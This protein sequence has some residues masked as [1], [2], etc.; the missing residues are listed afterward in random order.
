[1]EIVITLLGQETYFELPYQLTGWLGWLFLVFGL[2][3]S[4]TRVL[5]KRT[6]K[7]NFNKLAFGVLLISVPVCALFLGIRLPDDQTLPIPITPVE[8]FSP[9]L[10]F[11]AAIPWVFAAGLLSPVS[12][13]AIGL[14]SGVVA[15]LWETHSVFTPIEIAGIA[16]V[17]GL[18]IRQRYRT[19]F[20]KFLRHPIFSAIF[21][22][23][24]SIPFLLM[25]SFL[26]GKG[27][28][29]LRVDFA[30]TRIWP[31]LISQGGQ[32][33]I[34]SL[35]A[36]IV[37]L[38]GWKA[39]GSKGA[40]VPSPE[41]TSLLSRF[42]SRSIPV[43]ITLIVALL[44]GDWVVAGLSAR[45]LINDQLSNSAKIAA[46]GLPYFLESGQ[47]L[48]SSLAQPDLLQKSPSELE[49][50]FHN[51]IQNTFFFKQLYLFNEDGNPVS[52]YPVSDFGQLKI[53]IEENAGLRL[54]LK[55]VPVQIYTVPPEPGKNSAQISFIASILGENGSPAGVILGRTDLQSNPFTLSSLQ[56]LSEINKSGGE[57]LILDEHFRILFHPLPNLVMTNYLGK[58]PSSAQ[59]F[60]DTSPT[61]T[62]QLV[63]A[64]PLVGQ[65]WTV[66]VKVPAEQ[67][68]RLALNLSL[69][70]LGI[71]FLLLAVLLVTL[72]LG[73]N[74]VANSL[75]SLANETTLI[76][77]GQLD[78]PLKLEGEDE[79]GRLQKA[80]ERMRVSLRAR[81]FELNRLLNVSQGAASSLRIEDAILP[82]LEAAAVYGATSSRV[83]LARDV[84]DDSDKQNLYTQGIGPSTKDFS[85]IDRQ[86]FD[87]MREQASLSIPNSN[88]LRILRSAGQNIP[89]ALAAVALR[90]GSEYYGALWIGYN[91]PRV[92]TPEQI[93]FLKTLGGQATFTAVNAQL[94]A[95]T[96]LERRRLEAVLASTPEPVL[97]F[98]RNLCLVLCNPAAL[99][100][101]GLLASNQPGT[102]LSEVLIDQGLIGLILNNEANKV[103][104]REVTL[105][106]NRVYQASVSGVVHD[107][108]LMGKI[109][110]LQDITQFKELDTLKTELVATVSHDLRSPLTLMR[111]YATMLQMVGELNDQQK[112]YVNKINTGVETM[113]KLVGN[114]LDLSRIESGIRLKLSNISAQVVV[115]TVM[116]SLKPQANQKKIEINT[117]HVGEPEIMVEA[118][119]D[120][121]TQCLYNLL[122][123]AIKYTPINGRVEIS[124]ERQDDKVVFAVTDSGI[125]IAPL[126]LP[127]MF[128]KF[129]RS[130]RRESYQQRGTG[131]GL[132]IVKSIAERHNGRVWVE[133]LLGK[134]STFFLE[135]PLNQQ[136][137]E[138]AID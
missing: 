133:S 122:D 138:V 69:P 29:P 129:Y 65:P 105:E 52:G 7:N 135:L 54:A 56:A 84:E 121:L 112:T 128:E 40:L 26:S 20:Y 100:V 64:Q 48:I 71:L 46:E 104:S 96:D 30:I 85:S 57:G 61:G 132:A 81:L 5:K 3:F 115:E 45:R 42:F 137:D 23:V 15:M 39:W 94:Y 134:G 43:L 18:F 62:R 13:A 60:D 49:G 110:V 136:V 90:D 38:A 50:Y 93:Q 19:S 113:S 75:Q 97:M 87:F 53:S 106:N 91:E 36:E 68:Q 92:I 59:F 131:L 58:T 88:R 25:T 111:G 108:R 98:D 103:L 86:I 37:Y 126:D 117:N 12:A 114:L 89:G 66:L 32:L 72:Q 79:I 102:P 78:T 28:L 116:N 107:N 95:S 16:I 10:M 124:V 34:A 31:L 11:F 127:H 17:Y 73:I 1:M 119:A 123:N 55:G 74:S 21:V 41:E 80:F 14:A 67:V 77:Q 120:L 125:G 22:S 76:A 130:N 101:K 27:G 4:V 35:F 83:V 9:A 2:A 8:Y 109:C 63:Y 99:N 33:V 24:A 44:V 82:V 6:G 70:L 47:T 51:Q 118:D